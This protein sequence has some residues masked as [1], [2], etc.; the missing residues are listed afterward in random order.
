M[1]NT[2]SESLN[3]IELMETGT[4]PYILYNSF[5]RLKQFNLESG[6]QAIFYA[7]L[8]TTNLNGVIPFQ[9]IF[10]GEY[11]IEGQTITL[12]AFTEPLVIEFKDGVI[13]K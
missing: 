8:D 5:S 10:K 3:N 9:M 12:E 6:V 4:T 1:K 11:I 13:I 7:N 2:G